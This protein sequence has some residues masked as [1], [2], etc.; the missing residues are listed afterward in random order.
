VPPDSPPEEL[1]LGDFFALG[2][3]GDEDDLDV[4]VLGTDE[5]V[6]E[7]EEAARPLLFIV[8]MEPDVSMMHTTTA[9]DSSRTSV[10]RCR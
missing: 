1:L 3:M 7:E 6:E 4:A 10:M 5:L 8:S 9:F 2:V